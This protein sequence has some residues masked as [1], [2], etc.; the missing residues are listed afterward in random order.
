MVDYVTVSLFRSQFDLPWSKFAPKDTVVAKY[1]TTINIDKHREN[2]IT[3]Q[4][5]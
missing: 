2:K 3:F 4:L 1:N 5:N